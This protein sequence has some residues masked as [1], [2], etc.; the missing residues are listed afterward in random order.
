MMVFE[1]ICLQAPLLAAGPVPAG[2][3]RKASAVG[4][5][6]PRQ[7]RG[8]WAVAASRRCAGGAPHSGRNTTAQ[9]RPQSALTGRSTHLK[10]ASMTTTTTRAP[11]RSAEALRPCMARIFALRSQRRAFKPGE[12]GCPTRLRARNLPAEQAAATGRFVGLC[13]IIIFSA[14]RHFMRP[15][16][17]TTYRSLANRPAC[18]ASSLR[19]MQT[20]E[21]ALKLPARVQGG[22]RGAASGSRSACAAAAPNAA[23]PQPPPTA[24]PHERGA[25]Q[26]NNETRSGQCPEASR[27]AGGCSSARQPPL[28]QL[29]PQQAPPHCRQIRRTSAAPL[30]SLSAV[31]GRDAWLR[32]R[33]ASAAGGCVPPVLC[34]CVASA[35]THA[36]P[37]PG[38]PSS[39]HATRA[40]TC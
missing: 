30:G 5:S 7:R 2:R 11:C 29:P 21:G 31:L 23:P 4:R 20:W 32:S 24:P 6:C 34:K 37:L 8:C 18:H 17:R 12:R 35:V 25:N 9:A 10:L 14:R 22:C 19:T 3:P 40:D 15:H 38:T 27:A 36:P 39:R 1:G 13:K 28:S 16:I 26:R 33:P